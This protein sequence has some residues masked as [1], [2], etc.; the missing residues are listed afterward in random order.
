MLSA[1]L[2]KKKAF[3]KDKAVLCWQLVIVENI[4]QHVLCVF[5]STKAS[6]YKGGRN[7]HI[8]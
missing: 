6:D 2:L 4:H 8:S 5:Y 7:F 1:I 3:E